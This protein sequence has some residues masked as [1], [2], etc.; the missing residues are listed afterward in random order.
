M[1]IIRDRLYV[2]ENT[3]KFIVYLQLGFKSCY[4]IH[5]PCNIYKYIIYMINIYIYIYQ[6]INRTRF[7]INILISQVLCT[8]LKCTSHRNV[9]KLWDHFLDL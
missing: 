5:L 1:K 2:S 7:L 9:N 3:N 4:F 6:V 8:F